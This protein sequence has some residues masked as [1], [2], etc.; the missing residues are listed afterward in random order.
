MK[1]AIY[2]TGKISKMTSNFGSP[3]FLGRYVVQNVAAQKDGERSKVKVKVRVNT[4]GIFSVSTASMVE[5]VKAEENE[6]LIVETEVETVNQRPPE[7]S[8]DVR[9]S[10]FCSVLNKMHSFIIS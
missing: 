5:Q 3:L 6:D 2:N 1:D 8:N 7:N 10:V 4:H 9:W